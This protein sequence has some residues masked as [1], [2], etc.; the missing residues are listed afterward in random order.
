[1]PRT[2]SSTRGFSLI[3]LVVTLGIIVLSG[4]IFLALLSW[5]FR[6]SRESAAATTLQ[7]ESVEALDQMTR[8]TRGAADVISATD[9]HLTLD[10]YPRYPAASPDRIRYTVVGTRLIRGVTPPTGTPPTYDPADEV[11]RGLTNH[12]AQATNIFRYFDESGTELTS[13]VPLGLISLV[14]ITLTLED[15][16]LRNPQPFTSSSRVHLRNRKTNL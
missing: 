9:S 8:D 10:V 13:P 2:S 4:T 6:L 16:S 14:E 7:V 3:E 12:M 5:G 1:M 15:V 11:I